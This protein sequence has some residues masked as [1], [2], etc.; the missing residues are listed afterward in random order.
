MAGILNYYMGHP[1]RVARATVKTFF[2]A[3]VFMEYFYDIHATLGASML[4]TFH[5]YGD[6]LMSD[7]HYRRGRDVKVGDCVSFWSVYEPGGAVIKRVVGLEGDYV[8]R[9]TPGSGSDAM[10]QVKDFRKNLA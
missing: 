10:I 3:H 2:L 8:L 6:I 7:R 5:H 1:F 9:Y 4:P